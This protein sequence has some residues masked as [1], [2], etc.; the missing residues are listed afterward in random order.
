MIQLQIEWFM[1]RETPNNKY[2][3]LQEKI[4]KVFTIKK[5]S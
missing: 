2:K 3:I 1:F 5:E 4:V